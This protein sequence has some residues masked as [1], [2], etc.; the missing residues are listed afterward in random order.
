MRPSWSEQGP[1]LFHSPATD[2]FLPRTPIFS[3]ARPTLAIPQNFGARGMNPV[4]ILTN[5]SHMPI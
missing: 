2:A 3:R 5:N 1:L 4:T